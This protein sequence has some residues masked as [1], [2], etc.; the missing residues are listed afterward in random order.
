MSTG[1]LD[2]WHVTPD[3]PT[4][5][6]TVPGPGPWIATGFACPTCDQRTVTVRAVAEKDMIPRVCECGAS[7]LAMPDGEGGLCLGEDVCIACFRKRL[8][9]WLPGAGE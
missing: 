3:A 7:Y 4:I 2:P 8:D 1:C 6:Y 5:A 9:N